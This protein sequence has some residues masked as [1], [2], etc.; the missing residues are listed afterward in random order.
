MKCAAWPW[1][2][3][4]DIKEA[5]QESLTRVVDQRQAARGDRASLT[6]GTL[7][8]YAVAS[9]RPLTPL[10]A[11]RQE[12]VRPTSSAFSGCAACRPDRS[13]LRLPVSL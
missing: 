10:L 6:D 5:Q 11:L 4:A 1:S 12:V 9:A 3:E 2:P 8:D 7:P 13:T